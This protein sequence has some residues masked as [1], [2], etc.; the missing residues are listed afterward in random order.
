MSP[1]I[2]LGISKENFSNSSV[3]ASGF[4]MFYGSKYTTQV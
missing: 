3:M 2:F 4:D 1:V